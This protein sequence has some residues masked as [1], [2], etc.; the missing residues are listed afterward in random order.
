[1]EVADQ[2][3]HHLWSEDGLL[4]PSAP[5]ASSV[6]DKVTS[7]LQQSERAQSPGLRVSSLMRGRDASRLSRNSQA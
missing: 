3:E 5:E 2:P 7:L 1:M 6:A 4:L